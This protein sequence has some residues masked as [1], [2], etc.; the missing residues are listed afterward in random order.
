MPYWLRIT[1]FNMLEMIFYPR[2]SCGYLI[3][4]TTTSL[5]A[6]DDDTPKG[7]M[8]KLL[9]SPFL[10]ICNFFY[11]R[12]IVPK[13]AKKFYLDFVHRFHHDELHFMINMA[14]VPHPDALV[15]CGT[16]AQIGIYWRTTS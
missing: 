9:G 7:R 15:V 14:D 13:S 10:I 8:Q 5:I 1:T 2:Y 4:F 6:I 3:Q 12:K 16:S 11:V